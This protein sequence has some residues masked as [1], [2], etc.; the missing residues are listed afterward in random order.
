MQAGSATP[1]PISAQVKSSDSSAWA[2]ITVGS[3]TSEGMTFES[4]PSTATVTT[5]YE[6]GSASMGDGIMCL[7][8][9]TTGGSYTVSLKDSGGNVLASI[10]INAIAPEPK[11]EDITAID[12]LFNQNEYVADEKLETREGITRLGAVWVK[13]KGTWRKA[14]ASEISFSMAT[15]FPDTKKATLDYPPSGLSSFQITGVESGTANFTVSVKNNTNVTVTKQITVYPFL[16]WDTTTW[17]ASASLGSN[18]AVKDVAITPYGG[19]MSNRNFIRAFDKVVL[20]PATTN[21]SGVT[22]SSRVLG[23]GY[24][25]QFQGA[26]SFYA[27]SSVKLTAAAT[28]QVNDGPKLSL[29]FTFS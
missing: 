6:S 24:T 26:V 3:Y 28:V 8:T 29:T 13:D 22:V 4:D 21:P 23:E 10:N 27:Q 18:G 11:P 12:I 16:T 1:L 19:S 7:F 17:N 15:D 20:T 25:Q 14:D 9:P 5:N 2:Y